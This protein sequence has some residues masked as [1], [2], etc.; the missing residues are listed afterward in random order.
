MGHY[1]RSKY[2]GE[3]YVTQNAR[4]HLVCRAGWMMGGGPSKDKKF[5]QKLMKQIKD[6]KRELNV[7]HD[8][9]GTPTYTMDFAVNVKALLEHE[10]WGLYNMVCEGTTSR[11]EVAHEL[12]A[13]LGLKDRVRINEVSSE[14]FKQ[15]YFAPRPDSERLINRKLTLRDM[16]KMR[17]W[18][19]ALRIY[20]DA[21]YRNY[22]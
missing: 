1:A 21:S 6:G 10:Y 3:L 16:N 22:L 17:D 7:V 5:I 20:L 14:F 13:Q 2:M 12:V 18:R 15:Q 11:L 8:K 19:E 4:R 9:L